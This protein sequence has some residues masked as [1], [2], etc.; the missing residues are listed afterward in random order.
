LANQQAAFRYGLLIV[1]VQDN[2]TTF[3]HHI[4]SGVLISTVANLMPFTNFT[5]PYQNPS[6]VPEEYRKHHNLSKLF[7]ADGTYVRPAE[8][9]VTVWGMALLHQEYGVPL[10]ALEL[11]ISADFSQGTH[12]GGRRYQGR[13]D[14]IVHDDRY[15]GAGGGLDVAF[16][17]MEAM[18]PGKKFEGT[19]PEGWIEH[20]NR[21]NAYMSASP[22]ARYAIL[23]NGIHTKIYRRDLEY[24]R[25]LQ[26]IGDL[27]KYESARV[28]AQHSP[29]KVILNPSEPDGIQTGLQPLT[30]DKFREVLGDTR[31]GCHS[32]LR[33]NEGLQ[34][35]EAVDAMV[36]FLF[37]KW[38][39]EQATID[40]VK[41]T[42]EMRSYVFSYKQGET[43]PERL[44]VQVRDTFEKAKK[45][46]RDTLSEKF[47]DNLGIRLAFTESDALEFKPHTTQLI[48]ERL[49]PWSLRRSTAD[50]KGGVFE[51][52]L[53]KTFRDDLGQYFTPTPV[54]NLMVGILQ[55]TAHDFVGDPAC[56]SA[57]MLTHV[58]D[59]VRN[60]EMEGADAKG[61][62]VTNPDEPT[63]EF[64]E[65]R[66]NRLFGAEISR[67]V[68]HVAR[69]NCLMNGAQ[70]ADLK[71]IDALQ[72]L[73]SITGGIMEGLPTRPG[74]Y[75]GGLTMILTNPPFGSKVTS[76]GILK[77]LSGRDGVTRKSGKTVKTMPQE[78]VFLNRCLEFLKPGG[79]LAIVLPDGVLAN[80]QTQD[81]RD[82][83]FRWAK[84]KAVL[85]LPQE[86]FAPYG[87]GVKTSILVLQKRDVR[88]SQEQL[89]IGQ[90]ALEEEDYDVYMARI[91]S[92]GYDA[93][94]RLNVSEDE[95]HCPPDISG[96]I[97]KFNE[98]LGWL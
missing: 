55:P 1:L 52:F 62:E 31:S 80:S 76:E 65:F 58:L 43:D 42:G 87:A 12:Q 25:A 37:A 68:M 27:P 9:P 85:S 74:F 64:L 73:G 45:W 75:P 32:I 15:I 97:I 35:Q 8:D 70:Y 98:L 49:Q 51:D 57:R 26:E 67:N 95:S 93:T 94:G 60:R 59:Y 22:S 77:D 89:E 5:N 46:E 78:I 91:D 30:R 3:R 88:L 13:A 92:I 29:F 54:I 96:T 56:G 82:W 4:E 38:Y 48:V 20:L 90:E 63:Q 79:K 81:V 14:V 2:L 21:L 6:N 17:M 28:A 40:L 71:A 69:V 84:L 19:E 34:P 72:P 7:K 44:M 61:V 66:E 83:M 16:I 36:K 10:D 33:D 11:E 39:D 86:T 53:G 24:P 18:E 41:K 50:V 23:T 47:G